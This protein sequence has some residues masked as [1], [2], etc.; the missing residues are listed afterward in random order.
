MSSLSECM[1]EILEPVQKAA[2]KSYKFKGE[3]GERLRRIF[4]MVS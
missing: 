4:T 2:S 1:T 3:K